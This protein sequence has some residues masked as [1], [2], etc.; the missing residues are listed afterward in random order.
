V[1]VKLFAKSSRVDRRNAM[2]HALHP[3]HA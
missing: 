2:R 3:G 1:L